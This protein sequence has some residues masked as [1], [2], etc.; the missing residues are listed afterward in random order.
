MSMDSVR[1]CHRLKGGRPPGPPIRMLIRWRLGIT[2]NKEGNRLVIGKWLYYYW[3]G[4]PTWL[5]TES[6]TE[7]AIE[8][9]LLF[10][11]WR[12]TVCNWTIFFGSSA[13]LRILEECWAYKKWW[14]WP[15]QWKLLQ[16]ELAGE[17]WFNHSLLL[18][19]EFTLTRYEILSSYYFYLAT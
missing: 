4:P 12:I 1:Y 11:E 15:T 2:A 17:E 18:G 10:R 16:Y 3:G 7:V 19:L 14:W 9:D 13:D 8:E 6:T 5:E